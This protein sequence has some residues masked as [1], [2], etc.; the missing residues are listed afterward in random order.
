MHVI[1]DEYTHVQQQAALAN[2]E[3]PTVLTRSLIEGGAEFGAELISGHAANSQ[4]Q[5][6]RGDVK[7]KLR[8]PL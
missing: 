2:D 4:F 8:A 1:A 3:H 6:S 5:A 7:R